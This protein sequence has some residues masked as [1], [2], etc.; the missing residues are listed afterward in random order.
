MGFIPIEEFVAASPTFGRGAARGSLATT[1][2]RPVGAPGVPRGGMLGAFDGPGTVGEYADPDGSG[3]RV[4]V[5]VRQIPGGTAGTIETLREMAKLVK[6]PHGAL[7]P[8]VVLQARQIIAPLHLGN[9]DYVGEI[10]A[11]F[12]WVKDNFRYNLDP[13]RFEWIQAPTYSLR[14][15]SAGSDCDCASVLLCAL[16][17]ALGHGCAFRTVGADP[18]APQEFSHVFGIIGIRKGGRVEWYPADTT[19]PESVLGWEPP[20]NRLTRVKTWVVAYP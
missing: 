13:A 16:A 8:G 2:I 1:A 4:H 10:N 12:H 6:G 18:R 9:K 15:L 5:R 14:H 3:E 7:N 17:V 20:T 11:L 19:Q